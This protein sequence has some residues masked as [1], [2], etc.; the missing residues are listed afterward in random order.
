MNRKYVYYILGSTFLGLFLILTFFVGKSAKSEAS[1]EVH[2]ESPPFRTYI[3]GSGVVE[4]ASGNVIIGSPLNRTVEKINVSVNDPV[5]KGQALLQ[6]Y[7]QDL[8]SSLKGRQKRYEESVINWQKLKEMPRREDLCIAEAN[9]NRELAAFNQ[10]AVEYRLSRMCGKNRAERNIGFYK[11][12]QAQAELQAAMAQFEKIKC[13]AWAPDINMA[14]EAS[15]QAKAEEEALEAEV[16]RTILKAPIDGTVLQIK[17]HEGE[18]LEPGKTAVILGNVDEFNLRVSIDQ[19]N[20]ARFRPDCAA[21]AFKQGDI[22]TEFP[23]KFLYIEPYMLPKKY[24]TNELQEKVDTQIFEIVYRIER[25]DSHLF[26]G[27]Q[28]DVYIYVDKK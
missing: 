23:L 2:V 8:K 16:E 15:L 11:Y 7:N 19:F 13:G 26:V 3:S 28:M 9:L 12:Q 4:P 21:V 14:K 1:E 18:I 17:V 24:L 6:L 10:A 20:L 25:C 5:K 27:E 22:E